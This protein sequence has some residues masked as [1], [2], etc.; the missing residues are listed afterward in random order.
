MRFAT[1]LTVKEWPTDYPTPPAHCSRAK[2]FALLIL[3]YIYK[4][5]NYELLLFIYQSHGVFA[6]K[7]NILLP[8]LL[9]YYKRI[10][11]LSFSLSKSGMK[12]WTWTNNICELGEKGSKTNWIN[13]PLPLFH[14]FY[15]CDCNNLITLITDVEIDLYCADKD[16]FGP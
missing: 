2:L 12:L 5:K 6:V 3:F 7:S 10:H 4:S 9:N 14:V 1:N 16:H 11:N 8:F 13:R 15:L